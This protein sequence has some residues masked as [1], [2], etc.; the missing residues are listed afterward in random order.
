MAWD[1][2]LS[3]DV[4]KLMGIDDLTNTV[5]A[6][7]KARHIEQLLE[8]HQ[9][10]N[11]GVTV[12]ELSLMRERFTAQTCEQISAEILQRV[13]QHAVSQASASQEL[14]F[15]GEVP[16][17]VDIQNH[18]ADGQCSNAIVDLLQEADEA[19]I[20]ACIAY[21]GIGLEVSH[22]LRFTRRKGVMGVSLSEK[23]T[24]DSDG[25]WMRAPAKV[26]EWIEFLKRDE[27]FDT[28]P[29][30]WY[31]VLYAPNTNVMYGAAHTFATE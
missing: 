7:Q 29:M 4:L 3:E 17:C 5:A 12:A 19:L 16:E 23:W 25:W 11:N 18:V 6:A 27:S 10:D 15:K 20:A 13:D 14:L 2:N 21:G 28:N 26:L 30:T 31:Y 1:E 9:T 24:D 22:R 8:L